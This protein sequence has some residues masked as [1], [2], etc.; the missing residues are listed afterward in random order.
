M[1]VINSSVLR[2]V[3]A[4]GVINSIINIMI[5]MFEC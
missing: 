3:D 1:T 4:N 2:Y 5:T